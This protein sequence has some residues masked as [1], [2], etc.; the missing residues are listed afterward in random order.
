MPTGVTTEKQLWGHPSEKFIQGEDI[1]WNGSS[2]LVKQFIQIAT[3]FWPS[4]FAIS[5]DNQ[6]ISS[7][8]SL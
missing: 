7:D 5:H 8:T 3:D 2:L 6:Q 4:S 1:K